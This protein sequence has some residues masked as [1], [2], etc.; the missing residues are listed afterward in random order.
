MFIFF[1]L[2]PKFTNFIKTLYAKASLCVLQHGVFS[3]FFEIGRGCRQGDP[4]SPYLFLLCVEILGNKIREDGDITGIKL[5]DC[6]FKLIQYADDTCLILDGSE[7]S[8][9]SSINLI[10]QF[11]KFSG[12]RPNIEKTKCVWI[13]A[14]QNC[15]KKIC[16]EK[17]LL[18]IRHFLLFGN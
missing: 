12:L 16:I 1:N 10:D 15:D 17:K 4:I 2:G 9:R 14:K 3:E 5:G 8:L 18:W 7:L 11:A 6:E 13:G